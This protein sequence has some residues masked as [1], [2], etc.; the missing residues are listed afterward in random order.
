MKLIFNVSSTFYAIL[1]QRFEPMD[2]DADRLLAAA[3]QDRPDYQAAKVRLKA[4]ARRH[5]GG[6]NGKRAGADRA[7]A[8]S[9]PA[10]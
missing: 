4:Q 2:Y 8:C 9:R 7:K 1:G 6:A 3:V 10:D 5:F